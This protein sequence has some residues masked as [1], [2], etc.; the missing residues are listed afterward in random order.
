MS[1]QWREWVVAGLVAVSTA[2]CTKTVNQC[3]TDSDCKNVAY[4]FCDLNGEYPSSGGMSNICTIVPANCPVERCGC[5]PG[6]TTCSADQLVVC[7]PGGTTATTTSCSLG[8]ANTMDHCLTF[9]PSNGL[10]TTFAGASTQPDVTI[11]N[12]ATIDSGTGFIT[13]STGNLT[14]T[15]VIVPQPSGDIRVYVAK[16]F[17]FTNAK[18][19]GTKAVAFVAA[20]DI[21]ISGMVDASAS[22]PTGGPGEQLAPA[23]CRGTYTSAQAGGGGGN[24]TAGGAGEYRDV[25]NGPEA[26]TAAGVQQPTLS[27]LV[28]GCAGGGSGTSGNAGGAG[29]GAIQLVAGGTIH[30]EAAGFIDVGAGGGRPTAGGGSGGN[31]IFEAP[32]IIIDGGVAANGGAGGCPSASGEDGHPSAVFA[33]CGCSRIGADSFGGRGGTALLTPGPGNTGFISGLATGGYGGG[34]SVGQLRL[35]SR[36]GAYG[37]VATSVLSVSIDAGTLVID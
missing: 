11:P 23:G 34:G 8:C 6:A 26:A 4:P 7:D 33:P 29:G 31:L 17:S 14:V 13:G 22:G 30:I 32:S 5:E 15:S 12:N 28:G 18:I 20:G 16:S 37:M 19:T 21:T 10:R 1:H 27:S 2:A 9:T 36:D 25:P 24:L 3:E 35:R